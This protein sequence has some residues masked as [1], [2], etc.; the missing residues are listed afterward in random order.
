M[1]LTRFDV[2]TLDRLKMADWDV[3][4]KIEGTCE[5]VGDAVIKVPILERVEAAFHK[6]NCPDWPCSGVWSHHWEEGT[7]SN[8][9]LAWAQ[10]ELTRRISISLQHLGQTFFYRH[11]LLT[12]LLFWAPPL[13][14]AKQLT[15]CSLEIT[16]EAGI[17]KS[18]AGLQYTVNST[19]T[20]VG[21]LHK[22]GP[23]RSSP[24]L[25]AGWPR[26]WKAFVEGPHARNQPTDRLDQTKRGFTF[27]TATLACKKGTTPGPWHISPHKRLGLT[28]T[29]CTGTYSASHS[30]LSDSTLVIDSSFSCLLIQPLARF[31]WSIVSVSFVCWLYKAGH[32]IETPE[33]RENPQPYFTPAAKKSTHTP[34]GFVSLTISQ[35]GCHSRL[36][37]D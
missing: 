21:H 18:R 11:K 27:S 25:I 19:E 36:A 26:G 5:V 29:A 8:F 3:V 15:G 6:F 32:S 14:I 4:K 9:Q 28:H 20:R 1:E 31:D 33:K 16:R 23:M 34:V 10:V 35:P 22:P 37:H 24:G 13:A 30:P 2:E 17:G 7:T 12:F